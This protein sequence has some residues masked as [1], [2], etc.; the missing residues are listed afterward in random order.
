MATPEYLGSGLKDGVNMGRSATDLIGFY[1]LATPIA[2]R[3]GAAQAAITDASGGAAAATNGV[4]TITG[5]YNAAIL[6]NAFATI[7]AQ[8]N[9]LR[10]AMVALNLI[11]G[12]A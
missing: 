9:E 1:G 7:I 10:A 12:A 5:T 8:G 4:L 2:Q 11:K 3:A 6:S